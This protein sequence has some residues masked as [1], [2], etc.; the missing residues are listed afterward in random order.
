MRDDGTKKYN[1]GFI[2]GNA[3]RASF[4][5]LIPLPKLE[6][7]CVA[8]GLSICQSWRNNQSAYVIAQKKNM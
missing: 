7:Y 4:Y 3:T 8:S 2:L 6:S 1:D 5:G